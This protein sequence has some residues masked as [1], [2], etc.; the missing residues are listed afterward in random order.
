MTSPSLYQ[1]SPSVRPPAFFHALVFLFVKTYFQKCGIQ[2]SGV[3]EACHWALSCAFPCETISSAHTLL[4]EHLL[5]YVASHSTKPNVYG[6]PQCI[7]PQC[8]QATVY[9]GQ[10]SVCGQPQHQAQC[11]WPA[12]VYLATVNTGHSVSGHSVSGQPQHHAQCIWPATAPIPVYL[13]SH[14]VSGQCIR[15]QCTLATAPSPMHMASYGT[16]PIVS[17]QPQCR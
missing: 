10:P 6:Q 11:I 16:R 17:G 15:P 7:W 2:K 8:T 13:A 4:C 14:R 5:L 1:P 3:V 9:T 12:T